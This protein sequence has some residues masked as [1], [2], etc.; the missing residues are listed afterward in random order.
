MIVFIVFLIPPVVVGVALFGLVAA[1]LCRC[2][3]V[4]GV[5]RRP[6]QIIVLVPLLMVMYP[7]WSIHQN[8]IATAACVAANGPDE[9]SCTGELAGAF[10][11]MLR[12]GSLFGSLIAGPFIG[13]GLAKR[14][15]KSQGTAAK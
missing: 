5:I 13:M 2:L 3:L 7:A 10:M 12:W 1:V 11:D 4:A 6:W 9:L 14:W 8:Q 15:L